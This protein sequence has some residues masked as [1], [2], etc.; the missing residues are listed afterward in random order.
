MYRAVKFT[1][2]NMQMVLV[3]GAVPQMVVHLEL[4]SHQHYL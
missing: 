4:C 3:L 2:Y 1:T